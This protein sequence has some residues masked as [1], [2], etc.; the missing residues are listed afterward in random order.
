MTTPHLQNDDMALVI[1]PN[2]TNGKWNS[3]VDV[4]LVVM[5]KQNMSTD[6]MEEV[7]YIM[8]GLVAAFN[9]MNS[10]ENFAQLV[11]AELER[12]AESGEIVS[13]A[14]TKD[15]VVSLDQWTKTKGN[16]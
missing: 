8:H 2:I 4:Q 7:F 11:S 14:G 15:N 9:L 13:H 12:M 3:T 16:A 6:D 10:D 5:P 1:R